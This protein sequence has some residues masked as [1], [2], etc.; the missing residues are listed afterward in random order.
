M[1]FSYIRTGEEEGQNNI[2]LRLLISL[3]I[4]G[5]ICTILYV[6]FLTQ[7]RFISSATF[8]ISRQD[9]T[10]GV[11][12]GLTDLVLPGLIDSGSMDSQVAIGYINSSDLL[13]ELEKQFNLVEHYSSPV[14]DF[15]FRLSSDAPLEERLKYYRKHITAQFDPMTGLTVVE[16]D[17]FE[18]ALSQKVASAILQR[19]EEFVNALNKDIA[20]QQLAFIRSEIERTSQRV[21]DLHR[22]LFDL[23]NKHKFISPSEVISASLL[24]VQGMQMQKLQLD[25]EL[26]SLLRD[27]PE[28]PKIESLKSRIRSIN[29]LIETETA[30][31]SGSERDRLNQIL[32]EFKEIELKLDTAT[33]IRTGAEL[34]LEKNRTE[35]AATS[36]FISIIQ[37]PYLPEDVALPLRLYSSITIIII[38]AL[39]FYILKALFGSI[40][41]R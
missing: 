36:R 31:L 6:W 12:S 13:I 14:R 37:K 35:A 5:I 4:L 17:T 9:T 29:D 16:V 24:A 30:K 11:Q 34:M 32:M 28:S 39:V 7:D 15:I 1:Q 10:S 22:Q 23:Q 2:V 3:Y 20:E 41:E 8:K 26:A 40:F 38:A 18:S 33:R 21:D 27:S 25:A 19:S